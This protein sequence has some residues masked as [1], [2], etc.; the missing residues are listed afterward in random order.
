MTRKT[1][2]RKTNSRGVTYALLSDGATYEVWKLCINYNG[3]VHDG[4]SKTWRYVEKGLTE[5]AGR[6]LFD[7]R[8]K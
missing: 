6:K 3:K 7:R 8:T 2:S 5:E 1:L 4:L